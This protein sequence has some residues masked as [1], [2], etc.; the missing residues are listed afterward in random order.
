MLIRSSPD[1]V[2]P[3]LRL[4]H[5]LVAYQFPLILHDAPALWLFTGFHPDYH[6][7]TDRVDTIDF[8]KMTKI[9]RLSYL[10]LFAI[11]DAKQT[12]NFV[13]NPALGK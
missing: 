8:T 7:V 3:A 4:Q 10:T 9:V 1:F 13:A 6:N 11:V 5:A 12:P 2:H